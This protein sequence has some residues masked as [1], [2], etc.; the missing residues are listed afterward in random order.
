MA[1]YCRNCEALEAEVDALK[2]KLEVAKETMSWLEHMDEEM[3]ED[4]EDFL[5]GEE[6]E[7]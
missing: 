2:A 4:A 3:I 7:E 6:P 1:E 5:A